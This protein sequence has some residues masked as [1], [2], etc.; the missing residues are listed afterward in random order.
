M[1]RWPHP[2]INVAVTA[3][4]IASLY[5]GSLPR[6]AVAAAVVAAAATAL[7]A[8]IGMLVRRRSSRTADEQASRITFGAGIVVMTCTAGVALWWQN[9]VRSAVGATPVGWEWCA[10]ITVIPAA[11]VVAIVAAPRVAAVG[12]ACALALTAGLLAPAD[13]GA[14]ESG[15]GEQRATRVSTVV[16]APGPVLRGVLTPDDFDRAAEQL[17]DDWV[18]SGGQAARAVVLAVPTG[19]GWVDPA[20]VDGF[21]RRFG[22]VRVITLPYADVPSWKAFVS[23]RSGASESAIATARALA[24]ALRMAPAENRPEV[25]LY[26]Q[27]LGAVGADAARIWFEEHH[28]ELFDETVLTA[29]PADTVAE[30]SRTPRKILANHSDPV[31]RW[32]VSSL[33]HPHTD[34]GDTRRGGPRVPRA[35]WLPVVSFV[36]TSVDLLAALDGEAGVGHRYGTDQAGQTIGPRAAS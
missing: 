15:A 16:Q 5:P 20:A 7:G 17:V 9:V 36:Q 24:G 13:A 21:A 12:A 29:P 25:V 1:S 26:G 27:S 33:W 6:G 18:A 23:D 35:P 4:Y 8:I 31:V 22:D 11:V 19:S 30:S 14:D 10:A 3:A 28:P 2:A 34:T 32:S